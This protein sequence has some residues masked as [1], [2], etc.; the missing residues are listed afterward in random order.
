[1]IAAIDGAWLVT[2]T[3]SIPMDALAVSD[4]VLLVEEV[5]EHSPEVDQL[6]LLPGALEELGLPEAI[7]P[8]ELPHNWMIGTSRPRLAPAFKVKPEH[9][10][11]VEVLIGAYQIA[12]GDPWDGIDAAHSMVGQAVAFRDALRWRYEHSPIVTGWNLMHGLWAP[13]RRQKRLQGLPDHVEAFEEGRQVEIPYGSWCADKPSAQGWWHAFD[14]NAQRLAACSRLQLPLGPLRPCVPLSTDSHHC[15]YHHLTRDV[16]APGCA[17]PVMKAGWHTTPRIELAL[18]AKLPVAIDRSLVYDESIDYLTPFYE[19]L[20]DARGALQ[21]WPV[22]MKVLKDCYLQAIGRL[23]SSAAQQRN[24]PWWRPAWY[25]HI[26]GCE[27]GRQALHITNIAPRYPIV[28]VYFDT[29]II[30]TNDPNPSALLPVSDRLG[31]FRHLGSIPAYEAWEHM[32]RHDRRLNV[33]Q[34]LG[35]LRDHHGS[36]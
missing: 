33:K 10:R 2:E 30:A 22:A 5:H 7:G 18:Q 6:Y 4:A 12:T 34:L 28:G 1:M 8:N 3:A 13:E 31:H 24:S 23:R 14:I 36:A 29:L 11:E 15:G 25:D 20:R 27:L 16:F 9:G 26:I 32:D 17:M 35:E 19:R 21:G